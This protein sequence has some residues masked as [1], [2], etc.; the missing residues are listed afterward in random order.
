[1]DPEYIKVP[2]WVGGSQLSIPIRLHSKPIGILSA[3]H[4]DKYHFDTQDKETLEA[5]VRQAETLIENRERAKIH[6]ALSEAVQAISSRLNIEEILSN[7]AAQAYRILSWRAGNPAFFVHVARREDNILRFVS[8]SPASVKPQP[9]Q[10]EIDLDSPRKLD[11]P[12]LAAKTGCF[13][14]V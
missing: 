10:V 11:I 9:Q 7:L 13:Q 6:E 12:C 4:Q 3:E 8:A 14:H 1:L 2:G 5:L